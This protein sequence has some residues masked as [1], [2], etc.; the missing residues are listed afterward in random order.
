M[1]RRPRTFRWR[2]HRGG[3]GFFT[4]LTLGLVGMMLSPSPLVVLIAVACAFVGHLIGRQVVVPRCS[5]C[6][7]P[8]APPAERCGSCGAVMR[9]DIAQ[10][11]DRLAAEESLPDEERAA[12]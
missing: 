4:G 12:G 9:G 6:A 10:L 8:L 11:S 1:R 5:A 2:T 7:K 3:M